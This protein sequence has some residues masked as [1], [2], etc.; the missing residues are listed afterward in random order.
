M[1]PLRESDL[2]GIARSVSSL[3][4]AA[5]RATADILDGLTKPPGSLGRLEDVLVS[6]AGITGQPR[7]PLRPRTIV[8]AAADHGVARR[9]VSA[10]PAEVTAQMVANFAAG[11]AAI[12]VLARAIDASLVVVNAGVAG[13]AAGTV[14]RRRLRVRAT[15]RDRGTDDLSVGPAMSRADALAA[16]G[17]GLSVAADEVA[18]GAALTA[19]G[20][21]GIGNS[22]A[23]SAL[24]AA[25][26][27]EPPDLVTGRG[28]G[29]DEAGRRR[30]VAVIEEALAVN[31]PDPAD[32]L[33]VL[34]AV[35][36]LEIAVLVG[37][38]IGTGTA[39]V[40]ALLDGFITGAAALV[41]CRIA[42]PLASRLLASH[43]S[44]EPGHAVVLDELALRPLLELDLRLGEGTGAALAIGVLDAAVALRDEMATFGAAGVSG[45]T[46]PG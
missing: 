1:A 39:P 33:G 11:G 21:M 44:A 8:V 42:P 36:G 18:R 38:L 31:A 46:S 23:A 12:S 6:L 10:Y 29:L 30:K 34:A 20:E 16:I 3:D 22:T 7:A 41:A 40:P 43:R 28:T 32:P 37:V 26:T 35:G 15:G 24:T 5:M 19:V 2:A 4:E 27:G 14:S 9:G 45:R 13:V 17:T 25:L